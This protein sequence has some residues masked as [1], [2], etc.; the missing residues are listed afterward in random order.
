MAEVLVHVLSKLP[1]LWLVIFR[2][3]EEKGSAVK[4]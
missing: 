3:S 1:E 2:G 4:F